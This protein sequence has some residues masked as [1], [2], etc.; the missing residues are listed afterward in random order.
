MKKTLL[1][2][3]LVAATVAAF[4]QGKINFNNDT[5]HLVYFTTDQSSLVSGDSALAGFGMASTTVIA[6]APVIEADLWGGTAS[7][8]LSL[9]K[10]TTFSAVPGK[11]TATTTLLSSPLIL[12]G[13][14]VFWQVVIHDTRITGADVSSIQT[15]AGKSMNEYYGWSP[16][17]TAVCAASYV[18]LYATAS[19]TLSTWPVG[20]QD[21]SALYGAGA[22]GSIM[23]QANVPEPTSLALLGLGAA[24]LMIMRR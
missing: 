10:T 11:W 5:L 14:T 12:S 22:K 1:T 3:A 6:G 23:L 13:T 15:A 18:N 9:Y 2:L 17:F 20:T 21:L 19:P 8:A 4:A 16:I 7:T 24:S